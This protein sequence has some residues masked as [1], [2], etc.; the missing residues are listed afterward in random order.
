[1]LQCH[2]AGGAGDGPASSFAFPKPRNFTTG[3]FKIRTTA[4]GELPTDKDIFD[5]IS[6]GMHGTSMPAWEGALSE[7]DRWA[8]AHY[9]RTFFPGFADAKPQPVSF[10]KPPRVNA[11][12]I[13][14]GKA[15]F[16]KMQCAKCHGDQG[17]GDGPSSAG[18]VDDWGAHIDAADLTKPWNFRGGP[19]LRD[20]FLRFTTGVSGSP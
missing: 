4:S 14:E 3:T 16:E 1:C 15:L 11:A 2:G 10:G 6:K 17:R 18:L 5:T 20:I 12:L 19:T 8:L 9:V 7:K 13:T